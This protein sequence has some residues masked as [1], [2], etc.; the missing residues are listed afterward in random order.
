MWSL[1][2]REWRTVLIYIIAIIAMITIILCKNNYHIDE[3]F[4]FSLSNNASGWLNFEDGKVYRSD[5]LF[6]GNLAA[7]SG[8]LFDY[9][10]VWNNQANDVH[11]PLYY[12]L[13]H[14]ICSFTPN[15]INVWQPAI[16]NFLF[17]VLTLYMANRI[18]I[19]FAVQGKPD[20]TKY[21]ILV[22]LSLLLLALLPGI[23]N[24]VSFFRMYVIAMFMVTWVTFLML[25][26]VKSMFNSEVIKNRYWIELIIASSLS[27]LTHYY[28]IMYLVLIESIVF[29]YLLRH[30]KFRE[31]VLQVV[32][33]GIAAGVSIA[34]FPGMIKHVFSSGRGNEIRDNF[35]GVTGNTYWSQI[36]SFYMFVNRELFG[37]LLGVFILGIIVSVC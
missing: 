4:S 35:A 32:S 30:K 15:K 28:C 8:R 22:D 26:L 27:A 16:I 36:K 34:I 31:V 21:K 14:T 5:D 33:A 13:L 9:R 2:K 24:N 29:I 10:S 19:L 12:M 17:A 20:S 37:K 7:Q 1:M 25:T 11:P 23:L 3:L 6:T 18:F